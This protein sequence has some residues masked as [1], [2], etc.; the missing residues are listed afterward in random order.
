[1]GYL[2]QANIG[3]SDYKLAG[4]LWGTC[5][6]QTATAAKVV[7]CADFDDFEAGVTIAIAFTYANTAAATLNVNSKGAKNAYSAGTGAPQ[8]AANSVVSFTYNGTNWIQNDFQPNTDTKNTAGID[9]S[10]S[11]MYLVGSTTA[12]TSGTNGTARTY[13]NSNVYATDGA[14]HASSFNGVSMAA[15]SGIGVSIGTTTYSIQLQEG[16]SFILDDACAKGVDTSIASTTSTNL[17]TSAAVAAYVTAQIGDM[18]GALVY[19]GTASTAAAISGTSYKKGWY[20]VAADTFALTSSINVE[21]GDMIIAKQDKTSTFANDIDVVQT[22][23]DTLTT[24]E[25]DN[26]WAAA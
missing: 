5:A 4:A 20:W 7:A 14:L 25:I 16:D 6:T 18:A 3:G 24:T 22:N 23:I 12:P 26:L 13:A 11:K 19:K 8:W 2:T 15:L 9:S 1:M 10:T 21:P 17:P